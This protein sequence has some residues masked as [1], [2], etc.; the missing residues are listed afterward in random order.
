[1]IIYENHVLTI[2]D[3]SEKKT[4]SMG[5]LW[6]SGY[7]FRYEDGSYVAYDAADDL[8]K[9]VSVVPCDYEG[10]YSS[11]SSAVYPYCAQPGAVR[12]PVTLDGTAQY[13]FYLTLQNVIDDQNRSDNNKNPVTLLQNIS[14]DCAINSDVFIDMGSY[15]IN[16]TL[17]IADGADW[18]SILPTEF[19]RHGYKRPK[20][21]GG[22]EWRDSDTADAAVSSMTNVSIA[23]LPIPSMTLLLWA[24]GKATRS[25]PIGTTVRLEVTCTTGASVTFYI[26]KEGSD[27]LSRWRGKT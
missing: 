19:D 17:T 11:D 14:G 12:V 7:A 9:T 2:I 18:G 27:T 5:A 4:G 13:A 1:M 10:W 21:D 22:Y 20:G 23:R 8:T 24:N 3:S 6:V 15:S 26:Q 16:G 25:E